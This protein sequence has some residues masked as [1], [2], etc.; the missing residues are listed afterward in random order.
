MGAARLLQ[1]IADGADWRQANRT[2]FPDGS[3]GNGAA[4]RA[5]PIG[6]YYAD[7]AE[8][9]REAAAKAA[10]ITHAHR[11]GIEGGAL[12][13]EATA[14]A[15]TAPP[16]DVDTFFDQVGEVCEH[17]E[18]TDRLDHARHL[19]KARAADSPHQ[20]AEELGHNILAH[21]SAVTA[22]YLAVRHRE[23]GFETMMRTVVSVGG[24]VDTIGAM[25]GGIWGAHRGRA[26]LPE[27]PLARLEARNQIEAAAAQL[28]RA[29][30]R[31]EAEP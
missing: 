24:D 21:Q 20:I 3:F 14:A 28:S 4:M 17:R 9:R 2:V 1:A 10:E 11:L 22:V 7:D 31:E 12:I 30:V 23:D 18:F 5:A 13:A 25:A 16:L 19:V 8:A 6:L 29:I 26:A 27:A 15:L